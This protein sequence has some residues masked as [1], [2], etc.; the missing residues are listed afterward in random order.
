MSNS[1][2]IHCRH[3]AYLT[4][5]SRSV[6]CPSAPL[7]LKHDMFR[8]P[9]HQSYSAFL[10]CSALAN[11]CPRNFLVIYTGS[12]LL[13]FATHFFGSKTFTQ[14]LMLAPSSQSTSNEQHT[15]PKSLLVPRSSH[16]LSKISILPI[17]IK[18]PFLN[19][20]TISSPNPIYAPKAYLAFGSTRHPIPYLSNLVWALSLFP[21]L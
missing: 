13:Y 15:Q 9:P 6:A 18:S 17:D 7:Q 19:F 8:S 21:S 4:P 2:C 20:S 5:L 1:R 3:H 11:N 10:F 16:S 14:P 12:S